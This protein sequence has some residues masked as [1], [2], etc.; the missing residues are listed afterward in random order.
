MKIFQY[1]VGVRLLFFFFFF[2][3]RKW[4]MKR[5]V[6]RLRFSTDS[7]KKCREKHCEMLKARKRKKKSHVIRCE[8]RA[9]A[10]RW[11]PWNHT[12][13][14]EI[15]Q[16]KKKTT[17]TTASTRS[18][19]SKRKKNENEENEMKKSDTKIV[20]YIESSVVGCVDCWAAQRKPTKKRKTVWNFISRFVRFGRA[21][22]LLA[23]C[24]RQAKRWETREQKNKRKQQQRRRRHRR[25][26]RWKC[27]KSI[28]RT[29]A[30]AL[31]NMKFCWFFIWKC[32]E[33]HSS[34]RSSIFIWLCHQRSN[35]K[36][37][38]DWNIVRRFDDHR[39]PHKFSNESFAAFLELATIT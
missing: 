9:T 24:Q 33:M 39:Q 26:R 11:M 6:E 1:A 37:P 36:C 7:G 10:A 21:L 17:K 23:T 5:K 12:Q 2:A 4:E 8:K 32:T 18:K 28:K 27:E 16:K 14:E 31:T 35:Q 38:N 29:R 20:Y 25:W 3:V 34:C 19:K 30:R 15:S 13:Y 22:V